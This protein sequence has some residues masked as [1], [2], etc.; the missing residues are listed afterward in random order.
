M[1]WL[2]TSNFIEQHFE[3]DGKRGR[4]EKFSISR[5]LDQ[6]LE[7][8]S[9]SSSNAAFFRPGVEALYWNGVPIHRAVEVNGENQAGSNPEARFARGLD[10]LTVRPLDTSLPPAEKW[11]GITYK[12]AAGQTLTLTLE[13]PSSLDRSIERHAKKAPW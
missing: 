7:T 2:L 5:V 13:W 9:S 3:S 8:S 10:N 12:T 4:V 11:V 1:N 6:A